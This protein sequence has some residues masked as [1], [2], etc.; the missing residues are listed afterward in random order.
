MD[1][2]ALTGLLEKLSCLD[3][4]LTGS[5]TLRDVL[6]DLLRP[7]VSQVEADALGSL[8]GI[9]HCGR[10]NAPRLL[11]DAHMDEVGLL[12]TGQT[13]EGLLR[14]SAVGIDPR[15]LPAQEVTVL[16]KERV[17]GVIICPAF[18][19]KNRQAF[20][21]SELKIYTGLSKAELDRLVRPGDLVALKSY[22]QRAGSGLFAK[23]LDDRAGIVVILAALALLGNTVLNVDLCVSFTVQEETGCRGIIP[24]AAQIQPEYAV[25]LDTAHGAT[26]DSPDYVQ[27][28]VGKG[29]VIL[30][31]PNMD[32]SMTQGLI[33]AAESLV[34]PWQPEVCEDRTGSNARSLQISGTGVR[35][36]FLALPLKYMHT[37]SEFVS[38]SDLWN[39][40]RI[41]A[42]FTADFSGG[43]E[44]GS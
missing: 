39:A 37:P 25:V 27:L 14:F 16:G 34:I 41:L 20:P 17:S 1:Q 32:R 9:R 6:G 11:L 33:D 21:V 4:P 38:L 15:I 44:H 18:E 22:P 31:G 43:L 5:E 36:G 40:A 2:E 13:K 8:W 28:F 26:A 23:A 30:M 3:G 12:I 35:T 19:Q 7:S 24:A 42:K 29:P 10:K